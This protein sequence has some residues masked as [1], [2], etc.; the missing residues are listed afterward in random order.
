MSTLKRLCLGV[1]LVCCILAIPYNAISEPSIASLWKARAV[2]AGSRLE[3]L[4]A[5]LELM[6][7]K[8]QLKDRSPQ[9]KQVMAEVALESAYAS[10]IAL[11]KVVHKVDDKNEYFHLMLS[12]GDAGLLDFAYVYP[13][14]TNR[15][16]LTS[17]DSIPKEWSL[18]FMPPSY[19]KVQVFSPDGIAFQFDLSDPFAA[20]V[21]P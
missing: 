1:I 16:L 5:K 10:H 7:G 3:S 20:T 4:S 11:E 21:I 14:S 9:E 6:S 13:K 19:Q 2:D 8:A 17:I 18:I 12:A 15:L